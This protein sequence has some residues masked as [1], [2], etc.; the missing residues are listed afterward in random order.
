MV[1]KTTSL[2]EYIDSFIE[3]SNLQEVI[4]S[5]STACKT[6]SNSV[7]LA[8]INDLLGKTGD[9]NVQGEKVEKLDEFA[10]N[11]LINQLSKSKKVFMMG[12]EEIESIIL[13]KPENPN[14]EYI[15]VFDPLDGSSNIDVSI[16]IGTIFAIYKKIN[17]NQQ[18]VDN[19]LQKGNQILA[20]G[21]TVYG[22]STVLC[23]S[24]LN[25]TSLFTLSDNQEFFLTTE[26]IVHGDS[27]V[28]SINESNWNKFT[29]EN[30]LWVNK[31]RSGE[32]GKYTARYVGSLVADFHRNLIKGGVFAY[33][34]DPKSGIGRLRLIY[35]C[36]PLA[37]IAKQTKGRATDESEDILDIKPSALHQRVGLYIGG[38]EEINIR[39]KII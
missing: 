2:E 23:L 15:V 25:K 4:R 9:I 39:E 31:L 37:F 38:T 17:S 19:L 29:E 10:N 27:K 30:K 13:P 26:N 22:S 32:F 12:S 1:N 7:R 16:S 36:N 34:A 35:E 18:D 3:D 6:I 28:Y 14:A 5:V 33:P 8:G 21:Y 20:S 24:I 11:T